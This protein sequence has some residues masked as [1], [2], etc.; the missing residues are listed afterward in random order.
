LRD[1]HQ[2]VGDLEQL[3]ELFAH[4]QQ[5]A[6]GVA[7]REQL[8]AD[9][10]RGADVDAPRRL[11]GDQ[12]FRLLAD[13][14]ADDE[15]LQVAAREA[16]CRGLRVGRAHVECGDDLRRTGAHRV[17]ANEAASHEAA[18]ARRQQR[19]LGERHLGHGAATQ[20]LLGDEGQAAP[21]ARRG[22]EPSRR[23]AAQHDRVPA[24][25]RPLARQRRQQFLLSVA[26]D[27]RNADD[28]ARVHDERDSAERRAERIGRAH[29]ER[30]DDQRRRTGRGFAMLRMRQVAA[31]HH[32]R[33]RCR[34]LAPGVAL[35]RHFPGAE[36]RGAMAQRA[37]LVELVADV[38]DAATFGRERAQRCEQR[39]HRLRG[40][41]RRRLVHD[42]QPRLL[43]QAAHDLDALPLPDRHRVHVPPR[44]E[45][46]A[47]AL[48]DIAD[49]RGQRPR[50]GV[51]D[52]EPDVLADGQ[53][54]EQREML[55]HHADAELAR[56]RR[57]GEHDLLSH[58]A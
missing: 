7:Q 17:G 35:P 4:H 50:V 26:R 29:V 47:V 3:V 24:R 39:E 52:R 48:R 45:R 1:D 49:A 33:E 44:I 51:V 25:L 54:V 14:A 43:Q 37:D 16:A 40:E 46:Q 19:I 15:L 56:L 41:H 58:P 38:E 32:A 10:R 21:A 11:R 27:A 42:E 53:R 2:P 28:L 5:R 9:L 57:A 12:N 31:D 34:G 18:L 23:L 30:V 8:A 13:F 36:H 20:S 22:A 55:E 6:A